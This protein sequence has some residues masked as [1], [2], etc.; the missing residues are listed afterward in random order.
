M[1]VAQ[2]SDVSLESSPLL[3][4]R[5][6]AI[7]QFGAVRPF[8]YPVGR[9]ASRDDLRISVQCRREGQRRHASMHR[10]LLSLAQGEGGGHDFT[11]FLKSGKLDAMRIVPRTLGKQ[12]HISE[13]S[14]PMVV[15]LQTPPPGLRS[16]RCTM[17]A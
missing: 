13:R 14:Y 7:C 15:T 5:S 9:L 8:I 17:Q 16:P 2:A 3:G 4:A 10:A 1:S 6:Q 11:L 12:K